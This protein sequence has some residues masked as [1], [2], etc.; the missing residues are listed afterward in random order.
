[1]KKS[2]PIE[3]VL[4]LTTGFLLKIPFGDMHELAEHVLGYPVW[5]HEF[6]DAGTW[7]R[8]K[9]ALFAQH[10]SL[11]DAEVFDR[12]S[13]KLDLVTYL[14]RYVARAV[15]KYGPTLEIESGMSERTESPFASA[16]RLMGDRPVIAVIVPEDSN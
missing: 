11:Q 16:Q 3:T 8:I 1:M 12:A 15:A 10:P 5:T 2:Y 7:T 13:A 6:A 4:S 14:P 9:E